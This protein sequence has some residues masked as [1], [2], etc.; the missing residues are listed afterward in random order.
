MTNEQNLFNILTHDKNKNRMYR[1]N[2]NATIAYIE[3]TM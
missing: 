3:R 1:N 2:N